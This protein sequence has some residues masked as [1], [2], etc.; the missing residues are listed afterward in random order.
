MNNMNQ[1][2]YFLV[3][4]ASGLSLAGLWILYFWFFWKYRIDKTRQELFAIRDELFDYAASGDISFDDPAYGLLRTTMNGM[5][6]F[7]HEIY[8]LDLVALF[9]SKYLSTTPGNFTERFNEEINRIQSIE[10]R[11]KL[12]EFHIR[13][14]MVIVEHLI[15]SSIP[16]LVLAILLVIIIVIQEG[17]ENIKAV[18]ASKFP[19]ISEIDTIAAEVGRTA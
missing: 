5:V 12:K 15:K 14:N 3:I 17:W 10:A 8:F 9:I 19:G 6:R 18:L 2:D 11:K 13:M 4:V 1:I 7:T 16:L